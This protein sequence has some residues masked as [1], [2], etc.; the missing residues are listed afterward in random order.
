MCHGES[1]QNAK[2]EVDDDPHDCCLIRI[3]K[4]KKKK[5]ADGGR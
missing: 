1:W 5:K 4:V 2:K 3:R